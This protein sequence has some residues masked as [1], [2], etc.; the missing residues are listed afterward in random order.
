MPILLLKILPFFETVSDKINFNWI[1]IGDI[2]KK[3]RKCLIKFNVRKFKKKKRE[4]IFKKKPLIKYYLTILQGVS[5]LTSHHHH[6]VVLSLNI[7]CMY[8]QNFVSKYTH[9]QTSQRHQLVY[10]FPNSTSFF[11]LPPH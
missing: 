5:S 4:F 9:T 11:T 8:I 6:L 10:R 2:R 3:A 7:T 1:K